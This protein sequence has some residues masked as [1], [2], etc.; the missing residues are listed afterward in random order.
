MEVYSSRKLIWGVGAGL[1]LLA[2]LAFAIVWRLETTVMDEALASHTAIAERRW[3]MVVDRYARQAFSSDG[4]GLTSFRAKLLTAAEANPAVLDVAVVTPERE[5]VR[6]YSRHGRKEMPCI[7]KLPTEVFA[8][9]EHA[10]GAAGDSR[11]GCLSLP[12]TV[13]GMHH[14]S[15]VVHTMRDW[16][17]EGQRA[18]RTVKRTALRLA[19]VFL[20]FYLLLGGLLVL[21]GR[22]ARRWRARAA[23][24]ERVQALGAIADGINHEIRN[25]LNAV[26][27]S[28][29]LLERKEKDP[30][31]R[32]VI[33][34]ARRQTLRIGDTIEEFVSFT[35]VSHLNTRETDLRS[36]VAPLVGADVELRGDATAAV[37]GKLLRDAVEAMLGLLEPPVQVHLEQ[38]R[39]TWRLT[40]IGETAGL[41]AAGVEG[42][43]D[44]Y[45]RRRRGDIGRGLAL[46]RAIF[47]AHGG[48]LRAQLKGSTL[49][50]KGTAPVVPPGERS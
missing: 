22:T 4:G 45:L 33:E 42:L 36:V 28:L 48:S 43:F 6:L 29:Q 31:T 38:S 47:Q 27:L 37:D 34:E 11:V 9:H 30:D 35:R 16:L 12:I 46:A 17:D 10:P 19:P 44:P 7:A 39:S 8:N 3:Q 2:C 21:A 24:A 40:T 5:V 20:A 32:A 26:S 13:D 49:T 1:L 41:D 23:S 14:G 18:G 50:L 15:V 25:P